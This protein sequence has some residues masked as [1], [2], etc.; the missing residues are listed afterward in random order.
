MQVSRRHEDALDRFVRLRARNFAMVQRRGI[1]IWEWEAT[2]DGRNRASVFQVL[3]LLAREDVS[4]LAAIR[5]F[6][7]DGAQVC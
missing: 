4:A 7:R 5:S 1:D 3:S 2:T 6:A